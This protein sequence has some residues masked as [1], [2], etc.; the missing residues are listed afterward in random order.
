MPRPRGPHYRTTRQKMRGAVRDHEALNLYMRHG[1]S[2]REVGA[3]LGVTGRA[4]YD[5][6][7]RA[8][9]R[10]QQDNENL[11]QVW[12][13]RQLEF[14]HLVM[15]E[16]WAIV[17]KPCPVCAGAGM[18][19]ADNIERARVW[20]GMNPDGTPAYDDAGDEVQ[21]ADGMPVPLIGRQ[22]PRCD[23]AGYQHGAGTRLQAMD[24]HERACSHVAKLL[25]LYAPERHDHRHTVHSWRDELAQYSDEEIEIML[26]EQ[27]RRAR[28]AAAGTAYVADVVEGRALPPAA[29]QEA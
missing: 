10:I 12:L 16:A 26:L 24:R 14:H 2:Y 8:L 23:G 19:D 27:T 11:A 5:L 20:V 18:L 9:E 1:M 6:V 15:R 25:G 13:A 21:R 17:E 4:A 7:R 22:C 28:A 3:E 29:G